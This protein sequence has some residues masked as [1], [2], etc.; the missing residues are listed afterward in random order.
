MPGGGY[1]RAMELDLTDDAETLVA[2]VL[3]IASLGETEGP[4]DREHGE[5][6]VEG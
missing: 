1:G 4:T 6:E 2:M 5:E 3:E